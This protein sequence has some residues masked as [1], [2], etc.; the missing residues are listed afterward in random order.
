MSPWHYLKEGFWHRISLPLVGSIPVNAAALVGFAV[1]GLDNPAFWWAGA[2]WQTS[3]LSLTA[4][5]SAWRRR[6]DARHRQAAWRQIE[7]RRLQLYNQ[8]PPPSRHRH[9]QLRARFPTLLQPPAGSEPNASAELLAWLHL[10]LLHAAHQVARGHRPSAD[11]DAPRLHAGAAVE[12]TDPMQARL[13]EESIALL[14]PRLGFVDPLEPLLPALEMR[15][16]AITRELAVLAGQSVPTLPDMPPIPESASAPPLPGASTALPLPAPD[17]VDRLLKD[18]GAG[19]N[20]I[21]N[22][23]GI[24]QQE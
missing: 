13:A 11:P 17:E 21:A 9:H 4:G 16:A 5:R 10:K 23:P 6:M 8:L 3:W 22:S 18:L 1:A 15:L 24:S 14:D 20:T 7:E 2:A 12:I 19:P